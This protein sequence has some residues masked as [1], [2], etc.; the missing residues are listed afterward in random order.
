M[1]VVLAE[2]SVLI[3]EGIVRVLR[4]QGVQVVGEVGDAAAL[5]RVVEHH[6]PDLAVVDIRMPPSHEVEGIEAAVTIRANHPGTAVL[7]LSQYV[8]TDAAMKLLTGGAAGVGY[9]LKDRV[10]DIDEFIAAVHTVAAGGTAIDP[11]LVT[12]LIERP[13]RGRR[14]LDELTDRERGVLA[15]MAEGKSNQAIGAQLG[16]G[17]RTV[18]THISAIFDKLGLRPEPDDHRR[19]LAVL[20]YL[21]ATGA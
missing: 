8:E 15:L 13:H 10:S 19:V 2:D 11:S 5:L 14:P 12:R 21:K 6:R 4:D 9:L 16:L 3:R 1:R 7:L 17:R 20:T 18:E